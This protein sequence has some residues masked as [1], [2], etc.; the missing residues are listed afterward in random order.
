MGLV[1]SLLY[2]RACLAWQGLNVKLRPEEQVSSAEL[3]RIDMMWSA[4][5]GLSFQE[6]VAV[7]SLHTQGLRAALSAGEPKR[8]V[9]ALALESIL[10]ATPGPKTKSRVDRLLE[11]TVSLAK[12][13]T[14]SDTRGIVNLAIGG[15]AFLQV[16]MPDA[17]APLVEAEKLFS[18]RV[19]KA[20]WE[21]TTARS[22]LAW[23]YMHMGDFRS[24][25]HCLEVYQ[26]DAQDRG[27]LFLLSSIRSAGLPQ[28]QLAANQ[29]D[30]AQEGLD[31]LEQSVPYRQFQQR[32]VSMLYSQAQIDLYRVMD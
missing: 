7:A 28:L 2:Q 21:L 25:K 14:D 27:D 29:P 17:V 1:A 24:L 12:S 11:Q 22:L 8:V 26:Q 31:R 4:V 18:S 15:T 16:R 30:Q 19:P 3:Q 20:W 10:S 13:S 9:R 32:H 23:A 5:S 6:P